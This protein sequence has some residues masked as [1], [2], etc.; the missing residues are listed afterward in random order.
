MVKVLFIDDDPQAH[1]TL[2]FVLPEPYALLS[3]YTGAE[4]LAMM[5]AERPDV[6]LL[7]IGLPDVDGIRLLKEILARPSAPP[8]VMLTALSSV[9][10]VK[11]AIQAGAYDY[12]V[13]PYELVELEGTLC[14]A[15]RN[16]DS[17]T[18]VSEEREPEVH[19]IVGES[20]AIREVRQLIH[21]YGPSDSPVLIHGESGTGKELVAHAIHNVSRR[22]PRPFVALNCG[23][24]AESILETELFGSEKGAF[25]DAISKSGSFERANGGTLF[26]DEIGELSP[27]AQT[28][29]LR[30]LEEKAVT[31]VGATRATE[32][33]VRVISATNRDLKDEVRKG[34]FREDLYY[35][36]S[37]LPIRTPPLRERREDIIIIAVHLLGSLSRGEL[38][39]SQ[40]AREKLIAHAWPGNVRELR[41]VLER[42]LLA[43]GEPAG[44]GG[45]L[46]ERSILFD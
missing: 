16:V 12:M 9:R 27:K 18:V 8:V 19:G 28:R 13:K 1:K 23:A 39:L 29:L 21:R 22:S 26:L 6:V 36:L 43:M 24:F 31:R 38:G 5:S 14:R 41:N 7:D 25:T 34:A 4:G 30:V 44:S 20:A 35:R 42:S 37:V 17:R 2:D 11:E 33:D 45:C 32:A 46:E 15:V 40:G 3:A 10:L